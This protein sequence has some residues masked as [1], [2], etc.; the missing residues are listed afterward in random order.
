M[1]KDN[2]VV[3][4]NYGKTKV[5]VTVTDMSDNVYT[6]TNDIMVVSEE[7]IWISDVSVGESGNIDVEISALQEY[8][9]G[10]KVFA[11][12]YDEVNSIPTAIVS[13]SDM[14]TIPA[15]AKDTAKIITINPGQVLGTQKIAIFMLSNEDVDKAI[16]L[17]YIVDNTQGGTL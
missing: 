14:T 9:G 17:K 15:I 13:S 12:V 1:E 16:Y 2:K 6:F 10:D 8:A 7:G 11:I 5:T 3:A 4:T